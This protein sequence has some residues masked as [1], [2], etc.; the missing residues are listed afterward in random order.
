M[1]VYVL[2]M[3]VAAASTVAIYSE[4]RLHDALTLH[5]ALFPQ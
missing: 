1:A 3:A 2:Y 5:L 4:N